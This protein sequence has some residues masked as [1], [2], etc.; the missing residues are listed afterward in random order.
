MSLADTVGH[1]VLKVHQRV[2]EGTGGRIGHRVLGV[3]CLLLYTTGRRSGQR[4]TNALVYAKDGSE[5]VVVASAGGSDKAPG[6]YHNVKASQDVEYRIGPQLHQGKARVIERGDPDY[7]RLWR[8]VND[9]NRHRYEG[10]QKK[11]DRP[12]PLVAVGPA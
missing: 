12:I 4:R 6:W 10:Y 7:E 11:T 2:Y 9:K 8:L 3:P 1:Q 5:Y